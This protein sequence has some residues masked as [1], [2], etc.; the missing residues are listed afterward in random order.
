MN[1]SP[2][3]KT[4]EYLTPVMCAL[5]ERSSWQTCR[6]LGAI[7][8]ARSYRRKP[9]R[10]AEAVRNLQI[11]FPAMTET[12]ARQIMRRS[13]QSDMM[14]IC[15]LLRLRVASPQDV[16][17][18]VHIEGLEHL[19]DAMRDG[20]GAILTPGHFGAYNMMAARIAQEYAFT[21]L[22]IGGGATRM[23][24][25]VEASRKAANLAA[26]PP[27]QG[28]RVTFQ[29]LKNQGV[30]CLF[31]DLPGGPNDPRETFLNHTGTIQ[32]N[33]ARLSM[34]TGAPL[35][36]IFPVRRRPWIAGGTI[37]LKI[38]PPLRLDTKAVRDPEAYK[39]EIQ[40]GT[41]YVIQAI[42]EMVKRYPEEW[43]HWHEA[44]HL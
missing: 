29:A 17:D 24:K 39:A 5:I 12:R 37:V 23:Q 15:E 25:Q 36:P 16:R 8:G 21:A 32:S 22:S 27:E 13:R 18:Y 28:T 34:T 1:P 3:E 11:S 38:C 19:R 44:Q 41:H 31:A 6:S 14:N 40:R 33:A 42:G 10:C 7:L 4:Y 35:V 43:H 2:I 30:V 20:K 26:F 9:A